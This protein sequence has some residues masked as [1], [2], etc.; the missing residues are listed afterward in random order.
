LKGKR[1]AS[2]S[3]AKQGANH[4]HPGKVININIGGDVNDSTINVGDEN[5]IN[6]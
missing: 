2:R 5:E 1:L 3:T 6:K 4:S